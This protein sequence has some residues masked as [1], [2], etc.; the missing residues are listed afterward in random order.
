MRVREFVFTTSCQI[1]I[2][3]IR[4]SSTFSFGYRTQRGPLPGVVYTHSQLGK[5]KNGNEQPSRPAICRWTLTFSLSL[6]LVLSVR[7]NERDAVKLYIP[8]FKKKN[9]RKKILFGSCIKVVSSLSASL[10]SCPVIQPVSL[11]VIAQHENI[12]LLLSCVALVFV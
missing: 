1:I 2:I 6:L 3:I 4:H 8:G 10:V 11:K 5:K 9:L 7:C 12:T